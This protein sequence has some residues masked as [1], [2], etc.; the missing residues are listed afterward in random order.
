[1][2]TALRGPALYVRIVTA[3]RTAW[4][5]V[6]P[7]PPELDSDVDNLPSFERV[8]EVVRFNLL[9]LE[10]AISPNGGLRAWLKLNVLLA[11][12]LAVPVTLVVPLIT[13]LLGGFVTWTLLLTQIAEN[14]LRTAVVIFGLV[15]VVVLTGRIIKAQFT[16]SRRR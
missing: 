9:S 6:P 3:L 11:I 10:Q 8:A 1:M 15:L 7:P 13:L 16:S 14:L 5:P 4:R 2:E 12:V